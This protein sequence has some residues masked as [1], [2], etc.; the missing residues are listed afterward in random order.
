MIGIRR[1]KVFLK[2]VLQHF[3][4]LKGKN[5]RR[6]LFFNNFIGKEDSARYF[7]VNFQGFFITSFLKN[8]AGDRV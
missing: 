2:N 4:K 5:L 6:S 7:P 3:A 1:S 8:K